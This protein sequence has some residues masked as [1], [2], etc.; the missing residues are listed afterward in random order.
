[1]TLLG[2]LAAARGRAAR[3]ETQVLDEL[4]SQT[5]WLA[6]RQDLL[7][8]ND[9][10]SQSERTNAASTAATRE[11]LR[12]QVVATFV[13]GDRRQVL[14]GA[15]QDPEAMSRGEVFLDAL[16]AQRSNTLDEL[17]KRSAG[18]S[19]LATQLS[20]DLRPVEQALSESAA[21]LN[22]L[23]V[24]RTS[25][26][27]EV[28]AFAAGSHVYVPG[29]RIPVVGPVNFIDSWGFP[30]MAGTPKA[31]WHEGT[32]L[33]APVG[34]ELV[35]V[36]P[37]RIGR[38]GNDS[39]LGGERLWLIGSSGTEYYYAHLSGYGPGIVEGAEV[40]A[41]QVVGYVGA[42]GNASGGS[43][44]LHFEVHPGGGPAVNPYPL[45]ITAWG[46]VS[47]PSE[48]EALAGPGPVL[49]PGEQ[50]STVGVEA[51]GP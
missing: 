28:Q 50:F 2:E 20:S 49:R 51:P 6:R 40:I 45:L 17:A 19:A 1:M 48:A 36:E 35:A 16:R 42:T 47:M 9:R 10:V 8:G 37:G 18:L 25:T 44:H 3:L 14:L 31:H 27:A 46:S 21:R 43:A 15:L 4:A 24:A 13:R 41:G 11:S 23:E 33:M 5:P 34:R 30:R 26:N 12:R 32:D 39:G 29:F 22:Q 38:L 7:S